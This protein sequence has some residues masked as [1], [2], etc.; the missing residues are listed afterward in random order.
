MKKKMML[1]LIVILAALIA[2]GAYIGV[3]LARHGRD[4][5]GVTTLTEKNTVIMNAYT[6]DEFVS[7]TGMLSVAE[8]RRA[9][10][11]YKLKEG[12]FD[13]T[14]VSKTENTGDALPEFETETV[15]EEYDRKQDGIEGS[16]ELDFDL[17]AGE[18]EVTFTM[19]GA[20]GT[21]KLTETKK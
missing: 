14:F 5:V 16:G 2:A 18:Y 9:H 21:A 12:S 11:S 7:G 4:I 17:D 15:S 3:R 13:L 10:L 8:G 6:G 19:H 20:V 1:F